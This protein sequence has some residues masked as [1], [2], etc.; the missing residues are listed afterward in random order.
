MRLDKKVSAGDIKFVLASRIG[1][2]RWG[3][4]VPAPLLERVVSGLVS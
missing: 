1:K 3:Q 4:S 2:V